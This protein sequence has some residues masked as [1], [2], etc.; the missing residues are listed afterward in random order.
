[1]EHGF[2]HILLK[3][4][5]RIRWKLYLFLISFSRKRRLEREK[6]SEA[7]SN[8]NRVLSSMSSVREDRGSWDRGLLGF[9]LFF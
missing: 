6:K 1:M 8:E 3:I 4:S 9:S 2:K 7:N 5:S